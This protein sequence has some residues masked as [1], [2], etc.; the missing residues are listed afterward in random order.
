MAK[1]IT[2]EKMLEMLLVHGGARGA[3]AA[4]NVSQNAVY[5]RLRDDGFRQQYDALQGVIL[6]TAAAGMTSAL[7]KAVAALVGVLDNPDASPTLK[8]NAANSLLNHCVRYVEV[9]S[10]MRRIEALEIGMK[11]AL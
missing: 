11:E 6:S 3:A 4:L 7:D 9:S 1:K 2:D 10:V 8:L 5:K